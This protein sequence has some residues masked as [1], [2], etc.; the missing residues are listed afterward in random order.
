MPLLRKMVPSQPVTRADTP[1][2]KQV[3]SPYTRI[4]RQSTTKCQPNVRRAVMSSSRTR[5][6][7]WHPHHPSSKTSTSATIKNPD[8]PF[9]SIP[10][11][12]MERKTKPPNVSTFPA[13]KTSRGYG[14]IPANYNSKPPSPGLSSPCCTPGTLL[15]LNLVLR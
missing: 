14:T 9:S 4:W 8:A 1:R 11:E 5:N 7:G 15:P 12:D 6:Q 13:S 10:S 3:A 2:P